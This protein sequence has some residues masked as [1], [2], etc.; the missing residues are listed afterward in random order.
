MT[1]RCIRKIVMTTNNPMFDVNLTFLIKRK[2]GEKERDNFCMA[3]TAVK[4]TD[5]P[6]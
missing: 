3:A 6:T 1:I 5:L 2:V 4:M